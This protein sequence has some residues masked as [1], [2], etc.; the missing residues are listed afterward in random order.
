MIDNYDHFAQIVERQKRYPLTT[1]SVSPYTIRRWKISTRTSK[2]TVTIIVAAIISPNGSA[3]LTAP[4]KLA[5]ATVTVCTD[6]LVTVNDEANRYSFQ[7][8]MKASSPVVTR[9]GVVSGSHTI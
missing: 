2:G 4:R 7:A 3:W 6:G 9:A 1:P 8:A 5:I